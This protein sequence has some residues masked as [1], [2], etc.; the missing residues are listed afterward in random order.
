MSEDLQTGTNFFVKGWDKDSHKCPVGNWK[1][2]ARVG[3]P[4]SMHLN[5][6]Q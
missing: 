3:K 6:Y 2:L 1:M 4:K 5:I